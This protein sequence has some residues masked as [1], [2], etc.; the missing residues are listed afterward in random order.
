MWGGCMLHAWISPQIQQSS[1]PGPLRWRRFS[2]AKL[3]SVAHIFLAK[4]S[5]RFKY[6]YILAWG[7]FPW[8]EV[9]K[10]G[11]ELTNSSWS[12]LRFIRS[13]KRVLLCDWRIFQ[14]SL[15]SQQF[16]ASFVGSLLTWQVHSALCQGRIEAFTLL[17][18][19]LLRNSLQHFFSRT[20]R[21]GAV[22]PL[23]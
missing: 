2:G 4:W 20:Y 3:L 21:A 7:K 22:H 23:W 12:S 16:T 6:I 5:V 19:L 13:W 1:S 8:N 11:E 10:R 17:R 9:K 18:S 14:M 15:S